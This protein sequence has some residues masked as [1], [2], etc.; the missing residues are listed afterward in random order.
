M[1]VIKLNAIEKN[2]GG[3]VQENIWV[4]NHKR[5]FKSVRRLN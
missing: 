4:M 1:L 2:K 5:E 3:R